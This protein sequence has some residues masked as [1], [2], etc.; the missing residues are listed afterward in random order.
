MDD[1]ERARARA[2]ARARVH[3]QRRAALVLV[4]VALAA[5]L[6][7]AAIVYAR[8][9]HGGAAPAVAVHSSPSV[10]GPSG[11]PSARPRAS[12]SPHKSSSPSPSVHASSSPSAHT[13][14]SPP[15][16]PTYAG[17]PPIVSAPIPFSDSRRQQMAAYALRHYG[18]SSWHLDPK[19][20]VLHYTAGGTYAGARAVFMSNAANR[21]ELPG[22]VSHFIIDKD[23]TIYQLLPLDVMGRHTIGLNN[24]AI[25][26][27]FVQE[28]GSSAEQQIMARTK[29]IQAGLALVTWL[30][31]RYGI[32]D[33]NVLGHG[34]ANA[35]PLFKDL[36]GWKNDHTDWSAGPLAQFKTLLRRFK[37]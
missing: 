26:I 25:G 27:E 15:A 3:R 6:I 30:Q 18:A 28:G 37:Q 33:A 32:S 1:R 11:T 19:V 5:T 34:T 2:N 9:G 4:V 22:V 24:V 35:S 8:R 7:T 20:I 16:L 21:G 17:A 23:G 13:S 31:S 36:E 29:Q 10:T 14:T 12:A